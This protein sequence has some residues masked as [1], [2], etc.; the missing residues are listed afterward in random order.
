MEVEHYLLEQF[1]QQAFNAFEYT[2][3]L[4]GQTSFSGNDDN[5][6]SLSYTTWCKQCICKC[7]WCYVRWFR[8]Y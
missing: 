5:S 2:A 1:H 8:L 3:T 4:H 7:K 6:N